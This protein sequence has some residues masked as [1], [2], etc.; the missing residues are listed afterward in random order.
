MDQTDH[1]T[2]DPVIQHQKYACISILTSNSIKDTSGNP[3]ETGNHAKG[4]KIRGV[5][6]TMEEAQKR[7]EQIRSFDPYFNVFI[8]EVGKWLPWDDDI[9]RAEDAVYAEKKLNEIMRGYKEQQR[10]AK[11]YNEFR[12]QQD[13][14]RAIKLAQEKKKDEEKTEDSNIVV[15]EGLVDYKQDIVEKEKRLEKINKEL[16]E[17]RRLFEELKANKNNV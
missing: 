15:E 12:K 5:Y 3:I 16:E 1:L 10:K 11:E 8:G 13:I 14:E 4:F 9:E 7:C 17:A 6:A 2:E